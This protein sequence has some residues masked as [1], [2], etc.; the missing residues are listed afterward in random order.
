[1]APATVV[2]HK[3]AAEGLIGQNWEHKQPVT[4][5]ELSHSKG[6]IMRAPG[7]KALLL[8]SQT[9]HGASS[10]S[11]H[12]FILLT[13]PCETVSNIHVACRWQRMILSSPKGSLST[14]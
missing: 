11:Y 2:E 7:P 10:L 8:K 13:R 5:G 9:K 4:R 6:H 3:E 14:V 12:V 1:M